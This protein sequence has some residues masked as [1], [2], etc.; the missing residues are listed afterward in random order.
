MWDTSRLL[1]YREKRISE[2]A[3]K[4]RQ[5]EKWELH[6]HQNNLFATNQ[7]QLY[8]ELDGC[9]YIP[10]ETLDEA[11]EASEFGAIFCRYLEVLTKTFHGFPW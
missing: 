11:Q 1:T 9:N 8:Q 3:T 7:K 5:Y 4:I 2:G 6:Y 10:N